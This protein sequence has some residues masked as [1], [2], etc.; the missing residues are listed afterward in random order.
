MWT[1]MN[2]LQTNIHMDTFSYFFDLKKQKQK[3]VDKVSKKK[4]TI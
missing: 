2:F 4:Y 3:N 1:E